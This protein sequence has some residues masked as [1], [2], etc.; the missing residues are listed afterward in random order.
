MHLTR[1]LTRKYRPVTAMRPELSAP[2]DSGC[3]AASGVDRANHWNVGRGE[4]VASAQHG[5]SSP[6]RE[7]VSEAVP[8]VESGRMPSFAVS[9]PA[10]HC[11]CGQV[12]VYRHDVDLC[13]PLEPVDYVLPG[14]PQPGLDDNPELDKDGRRHQ[15][16]EGVLQVGGKV[17]AA[18]FAEDHRDGRRRIDDEASA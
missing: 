9:A 10:T 13:V 6:L 3:P 16:D 15:P 4:I 1:P 11:T 17:L 5:M 7:R 2:E 14:R 8:E 18:W 12:G